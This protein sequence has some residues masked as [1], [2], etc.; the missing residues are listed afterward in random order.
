M[1]TAALLR[2][3]ELD[4]AKKLRRLA[5]KYEAEAKRLR[6]LIGSKGKGSRKL[7]SKARKAIAA[8][9]RARWAKVRAAKKPA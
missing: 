5:N 6:K 2:R 3:E 9:Q 7:S 4:I 1:N 8:A